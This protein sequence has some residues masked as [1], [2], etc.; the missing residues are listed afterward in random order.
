MRF[1][2]LA[3]IMAVAAIQV[4]AVPSNAVQQADLGAFFAHP[5]NAFERVEYRVVGVT[6]IRST[7]VV[8]VEIPLDATLPAGWV[9]RLQAMLQTTGQKTEIR[10]V[11][12]ISSPNLVEMGDLEQSAALQKGL[13]VDPGTGVAFK[14]NGLHGTIGCRLTNGATFLLSNN[15]V[16]ANTDRVATGATTFQG[17]LPIR[18]LAAVQ[19]LSLSSDNLIDAA[20]A[21]TTPQCVTTKTPD[22]A[23]ASKT[24]QA[25]ASLNV[26]K[27]GNKTRGVRV[28]EIESTG[29][30]YE[31]KL[32]DGNAYCFADQILVRSEDRKLP[33]AEDGDSGSVAVDGDN[34]A[35]GLFFA[36][37]KG[38]PH[39]RAE[40]GPP[41]FS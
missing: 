4:S 33:F 41:G 10:L 36:R 15:H 17:K 39:R 24:R 12:G 21:C 25:E 29:G 13:P 30:L 40:R 2:A 28:G 31:V 7:V 32:T 6:L 11:S 34:Q 8:F 18:A 26:K 14:E 27:W 16:L 35:V 9:S 19:C 3:V 5:G 1:P 38:P 22:F 20:L 23:F 37:I